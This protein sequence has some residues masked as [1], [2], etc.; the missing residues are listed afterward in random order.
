[1]DRYRIA[2]LTSSRA[3]YGIYRP[4]LEK[5]KADSWFSTKIIAFGT[6]LSSLYG[7]TLNEI[8][9][10]GFSVDYTV[11]NQL[12]GDSPEAISS[13][14]GL[15]TL[16]FSSIWQNLKNDIDLIICLGD[17]Y[18]M[19]AA[20]QASLPFQ[21]P[22]AHIHGGETTL[23]AID[24]IFRHSLTFMAKYHFVSSKQ[25]QQ[26][27][28]Q[29]IGTENDIDN[30]YNVGALGLDNL[31]KI[32][33]FTLSEFWD[34]YQINIE[35]PTILLTFHPETVSFEENITFATI[36]CEVLEEIITNKKVQFIDYQIIITMPN[37]DTMGNSIRKIFTDFGERKEK[38]IFLI[39]NFGTKGYFSCMKYCSLLLGNTS[40]GIIEAASFKKYVINLGDRQK[41]RLAGEN[42][43]NIEIDKEKILESIKKIQKM[44]VLDGYNIYGNGSASNKIIDVLKSLKSTIKM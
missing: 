19:F 14:I 42:V 38:K 41:G 2:L 31:E 10:D 27:V 18:E 7:N 9:Q 12:L 37:A 21:I 40:S 28:K 17:R 15:T 25:H 3:D 16:K 39:E 20:V 30:I 32:Q 35:K 5:L 13:T 43:L 26:K 24:N 33:L 44:P 34:K 4:L 1:M 29:L 8:L 11:E 6:H 22:V 23:G 36:I